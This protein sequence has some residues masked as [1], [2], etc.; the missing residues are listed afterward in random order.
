[1]I[2]CVVAPPN[3]GKTL[4]AFFFAMQVA[5]AS[6][7]VAIIEEEGGKRGFQ[8]R[9]DRASRA[10]GNPVGVSYSFKPRI[11]LMNPID[12]RALADELKGYDLVIIDSFARVTTGVEEN[13]SKEMGQIVA[14]VDFIREKTGATILLIHHTGKSKWKPGEVP[15]LADGRGSSAFA[16]G[17]DTVLALAPV[18]E[19]EPGIVTF[20]LHVTKQRD[21]DNQVPPRLVKIAMTGPSADVTMEERKRTGPGPTPSEQRIAAILPLVFMAIPEPPAAAITRENLQEQ[22]GRRASDV[23]AAVAQLVD[24]KKVKELSRKRLIR[25]PSGYR[26]RAE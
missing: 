1:V 19:Q 20:E 26:E 2:A 6:R 18:L 21:E 3:L 13:D 4:L 14:A 17:L 10:C 24:Q 11:S 16:A 23:R 25:V 12:I 9:I 22:I 7:R 15:T 5:G 8:K